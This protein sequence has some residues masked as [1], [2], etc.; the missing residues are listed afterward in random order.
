MGDRFGVV[1]LAFAAFSTTLLTPDE[2]P[3]RRHI[4]AELPATMDSE[5][6][7]LRETAAGLF[8]LRMYREH[9]VS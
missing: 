5:I 1:D 3:I 7:G 6:R 8:A 4:Q 9:R 2:H